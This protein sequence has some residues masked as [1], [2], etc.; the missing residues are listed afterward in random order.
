ML[1]L[2]A[3]LKV[4]KRGTVELISE[5]EL[6]K[7][8]EKKTS[9]RIKTGFD[10]TAPDLHLGHTVLIQKMKQLQLLGHEIFFLIGDFTGMIGDPSGK[11]HTRRFLTRQEVLKNAETYQRQIFKI[12]DSTK[13]KIVFN[14]QWLAE[15][16]AQGLIELTSKYTVARMLERDDF[17]R[18]FTSKRPIGVHEFI[19]PLLQGFDSIKL[20]A[21]VE[22]GGTDQKFNL[23]V[24]RELQKEYGQEPQVVITLPLLIGID[25][26]NK[27]SKTYNN[28][29]AI[30]ESPKEIY[31]KIMS[32]SDKLMWSY[33][34][35]LSNLSMGE[36]ENLRE[37]V[38]HE[39]LNPMEVKKGL[40][41][42]I[43]SRFHGEEKA[44]LAE[45]EFIRQFKEKQLPEDIPIYIK[46]ASRDK[47]WICELLREI[48]IIPSHGEA[49]RLIKQAGLKLNGQRVMDEFLGVEQEGE[50]IIQAGKRKFAKVI[51][52]K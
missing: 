14:S 41:R 9:L 40:A 34:E 17:Q 7:K 31:G 5:E 26:V 8:L 15:M 36:V 51:F 27:M 48:K 43:V 47:V 45:K 24:G 10:P 2:D 52:Q 28:Y 37:K 44:F 1:D 49:R 39:G 13:T 6:I 4:F 33:L 42:E 22:L 50:I 35:L 3:Q 30:E 19:Y 11:T 46:K 16:N 21:D 20:N 29:I 18:R 23:L 12:L 32:I 38:S 25:G